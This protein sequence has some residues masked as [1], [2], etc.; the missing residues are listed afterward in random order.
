V[1]VAELRVYSTAQRVYVCVWVNFNGVH[2]S[3]SA[4][5][6]GWGYS[7]RNAAAHYALSSLFVNYND[8][9]GS[10]DWDPAMNLSKFLLVVFGLTSNE[11]VILEAHG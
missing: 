5:A 7:L 1:T 8:L 9:K 10:E 3:A 4:W 11:H 6:G 2:L